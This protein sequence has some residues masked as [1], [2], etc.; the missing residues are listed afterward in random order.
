MPAI[1]LAFIFAAGGMYQCSHPLAG[2]P[3]EID[4]VLMLRNMKH[5]DLS[6]H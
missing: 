1:R 3:A 4:V 6:T 5:P 2:N